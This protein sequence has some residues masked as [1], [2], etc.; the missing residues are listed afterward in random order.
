VTQAL[1]RNVGTCRSDAKGEAQVGRPHKG[2]STE[3][4]HRDGVARS[5]EEGPVMGLERRGDIV[6]LYR[7]VNQR[8]EELDG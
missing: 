4:E 3:T 8:W 1:M 2:E 6:Q 5:S 7:R